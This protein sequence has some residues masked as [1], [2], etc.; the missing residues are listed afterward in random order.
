MAQ[1]RMFSKKITDTDMF[2]DMP[3][4]AQALYFHL[5]M[6]ADDDGFVDNVKTLKRMIGSSDDDL[7]L[8]LTKQFIIVFD[9]GITVIKDWRV[10]NYLRK[11][12][13]TATNYKDHRKELEITE[14]GSYQRLASASTTGIPPVDDPSPQVRLGKDRLGKDRLGQ[15]T[16]GEQEKEKPEPVVDDGR[17]TPEYRTA[18]VDYY[19]ETAKL[20]MIPPAWYQDLDEDFADWLKINNDPKEVANIFCLAIKET[21]ATRN[22]HRPFK[23]MQKILD[24]WERNKLTTVKEIKANI[25]DEESSSQ[26][27]SKNYNYRKRSVVQKEQLPDWADK[28][29]HED[30]E[31]SAEVRADLAKRMKDLGIGKKE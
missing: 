15:S 17:I 22:V 28:K 26:G 1:R 3:L 6:H 14:S 21:A 19:Q 16:T 13:Y 5:N 2:L 12:R 29:D 25:A 8:L 30:T 9:D 20:G 10:H 23:Y 4:S 11:D 31:A 27:D 24:N 7:K 18:V